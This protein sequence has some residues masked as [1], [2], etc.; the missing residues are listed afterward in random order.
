MEIYVFLEAIVG[1]I[2]AI[3]IAKRAKRVEGVAYGTLDRAGKVTNV[4]LSILYIAAAPVC[5]L[6]GAIGSPCAEGFLWV[7]ALIVALIN[8]SAP[9]FAAL[10]IGFSVALRKEGKSKASFLVQFA[11]ILGIALTFALSSLFSGSL[12]ST[13]N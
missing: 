4:L 1:V 7:I 3:V 10:G 9:L 12:L 11:G 8:S 6:L 2:L 5:M 13:L